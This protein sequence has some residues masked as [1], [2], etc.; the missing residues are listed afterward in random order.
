MNTRHTCHAHGCEVAVPPKMFMCKRHWYSLPKN[1]RDAIWNEYT[2][3]QERTKKPTARYMAVQRLAVSR[4]AFKPHDEEAALV[5]AGY[6]QEALAF[7]Q[8][9]IEAG[10]GDPLEG[11]IPDSK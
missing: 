1:L 2:P 6:L 9:A 5:A 10:H 7:Q 8:L 3:G 11:L 4:T